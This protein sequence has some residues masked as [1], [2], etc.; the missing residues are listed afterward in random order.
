VLIGSPA[1]TVSGTSTTKPNEIQLTLLAVEPD[2]FPSGTNQSVLLEDAKGRGVVARGDVADPQSKLTITTSSAD[3]SAL[4]PP[5]RVLFN[6]LSISRGQTAASEILGSGDASVAGQEFVLKNS[7][8]TYLLSG[9]SSSGS[10][11]ASTLRIWVND[12]EWKEVPSFYGQSATARIF[13]TR[14]DENDRTH[15]QFGDGI[16]GARLPSGINNVIAR[17]RYGSGADTPTAG[18]LSTILKPYPNLK[19]IRN[20]VAVG[21]GSDPD[22]PEQIRR[23]APQSVLTFGRAVSGND[24][25][26]IAAQAPGVDRAKAYWSWDNEQQRTL[27]KV[28]V[29]DDDSAVKSAQVALAGAADPNRSVKIKKAT[30]IP[31][32]LV[33]ILRLD[34]AYL[35]APVLE[36]VREALLNAKTGLLGTTAIRIGRAI[37]RSQIYRTCLVPGVLAVTKLQ[38][39]ADKGT[40]FQQDT[41]YRYDPGEGG[42][43]QISA[44]NLKL[45]SEVG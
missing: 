7:P 9:T 39:W 17:Y 34:S 18:S 35:P 44:D 14:E 19:A 21:G 15:I 6:P 4:T 43:Y 40:G 22:P 5:L 30:A 41:S 29:G 16:N 26:A 12:I 37:Y 28:Y 1:T 33:L 38:F 31:L 42:F 32:Q 27:V 45:S 2:K 10:N 8:L 11:Y 25:E 23:Y 13:V 3:L 24:Y 20:P 36:G